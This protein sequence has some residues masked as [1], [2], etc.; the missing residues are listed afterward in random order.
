LDSEE[1]EETTTK[2]GK[3]VV[4]KNK[5][6]QVCLAYRRNIR[7]NSCR[8]VIPWTSF[9]IMYLSTIFTLL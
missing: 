1:E 9:K 8:K 5:K 7:D 2:R 6:N 3:S 4:A